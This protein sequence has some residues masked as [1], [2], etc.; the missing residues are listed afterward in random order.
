MAYKAVYYNFRDMLGSLSY[1][2][3]HLQPSFNFQADVLGVNLFPGCQVN[4]LVEKK[5]KASNFLTTAL[6]NC[7]NTNFLLQL[8]LTSLQTPTPFIIIIFLLDTPQNS[9]FPEGLSCCLWQELFSF[10]YWHR[11]CC[12]YRN[13][14]TGL[15]Q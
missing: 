3:T 8:S 4:T 15:W 6:I 5:V 13:L 9:L 14:Y 11:F 2:N 1:W 10:K 7:L 12:A